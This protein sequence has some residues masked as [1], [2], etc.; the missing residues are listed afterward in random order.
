MVA[1]ILLYCANLPI[2]D[3]TWPAK[4]NMAVRPR[5]LFKPFMMVS[6][7]KNLLYFDLVAQGELDQLLTIAGLSMLIFCR[8]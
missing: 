3:A 7:L 5:R 2:L 4:R 8:N 6:E 1:S